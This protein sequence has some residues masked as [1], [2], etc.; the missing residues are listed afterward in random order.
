MYQGYIVSELIGGMGTLPTSTLPIENP[1]TRDA[2][3]DRFEIVWIPVPNAL[4]HLALGGINQFVAPIAAG[5]IWLLLYLVLAALCGYLVAKSQKYGGEMQFIFTIAIA[6]GPGF[7]NG[8]INFQYSVLLFAVFVGLGLVRRIKWIFLFSLLIYF[9]HGSVYAGFVCYVFLSARPGERPGERP[10]KHRTAVFCALLPSLCLLLWYTTTR[11]LDGG[12]KN[13]GLGSLSQWVQY[14]AYTLAKQ[15][16]FH[17]FIQ[18]DGRSLLES[19]NSLYM[20]GFVVNFVIALLIGC[21]LLLVFWRFASESFNTKG[22]QLK[23]DLKRNR[24]SSLQDG[25]NSSQSGALNIGLTG[26]VFVLLVAWLLAGKN[27]LGVVNLGERFLIAGLMLMLLS[28]PCPSVIRRVWL[29]L[30]ALVTC[31]TL[32]A[33]FVIS[34]SAEQSY[35]VARSGDSATLENYVDEIYKNSQ[36]KYF[37]HRLFIYAELGQYLLNPTEYEAVPAIDLQTSIVRAR[38]E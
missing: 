2:L 15:G 35:S 33:L 38:D 13:L 27:S 22:Y 26:T 14:K 16:P 25:N 29:G 6:F 10:G 20:I 24:K 31:G 21:W 18:H 17:N 32:S 12:D 23:S 7:W 1:V 34:Q 5:K 36:H 9:S 8:Y 19:L 30:C 28:I 3:A 4:T 11:L 37:N